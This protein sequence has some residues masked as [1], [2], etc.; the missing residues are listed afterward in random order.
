MAVDK[1][2]CVVRF[3]NNNTLSSIPSEIGNLMALTGLF[4]LNNQLMSIPSEV[5]KLTK[6]DAL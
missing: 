2:T 5:G 3:L 4:L 6:L 1:L